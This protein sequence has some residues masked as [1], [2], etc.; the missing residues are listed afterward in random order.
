MPEE[1]EAAQEAEHHGSPWPIVV[2][3]GFGI[4]LI[5]LALVGPVLLSP[6]FLLGLAVFGAGL[7]GWAHDDYRGRRVPH[8]PG[9]RAGPEGTLEAFPA[10]KAA[11]WVFLASEI[12]F[13]SG[14]IGGS[15]AVRVGAGEWVEPGAV[16]NVPLTALNTFILITSSLAMAEALHA[17]QEGKQ[18][19]LVYRLLLV[20][21]LGLFF[22]SIQG[23]E[24]FTLIHEGL[25]PWSSPEGPAAYGATFFIQT[26]FH[27]AHVTG[28]LVALAY[29]TLKASRGAFTAENHE[30]VELMGLYW[31]FVDV[32]WIFLFT[33]VYLV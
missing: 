12:M 29:V 23:F 16:L 9:E 3:T 24:Y 2:G 1:G 10:R 30:T 20:L 21:A 11:M 5:S 22:I 15:W 13:F 17:V 27:G 32:V 31:H 28:G 7:G 4:M 8:V 6:G 19:Q 18:Q 14:I 25:T 33:I 26:G